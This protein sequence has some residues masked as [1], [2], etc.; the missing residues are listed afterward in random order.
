MQQPKNQEGTEKCR[1]LLFCRTCRGPFISTE[2]A[3]NQPTD[4]TLYL[5]IYFISLKEKKSYESSMRTVTVDYSMR[6]R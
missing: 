3:Q 4:F 2:T 5:E 6:F 1:K